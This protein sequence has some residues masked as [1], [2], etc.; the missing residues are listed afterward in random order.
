MP[1]HDGRVSVWLEPEKKRL[2]WYAP[3]GSRKSK[4]IIDYDSLSENEIENL[5][6]TLELTFNNGNVNPITGIL[7]PTVITMSQLWAHYQENQ[8]LHL[9]GDSRKC[10]EA[11]WRLYIGPR[12]GKTKIDLVKTLDVERWLSEVKK[13][14]GK[15]PSKEY[16]EKIRNVMSAMFSHAMRAELCNQNPISCGGSNIGHGGK[17]GTGAGA[18]ILGEFAEKRSL[19]HF[20]PEQNLAILGELEVRDRALVLLDAVLGLRRGELGGLHWEDCRFDADVFVIRHSFDWKG[21]IENPPKTERSAAKLP[22]HA[23]LK[24]ALLMWQKETPYQRPQDYVFPSQKM[25]GRKPVDLKEVFVKKIRPVIERLGFAQPRDRYGWHSF[26]HGLGTAL[27]DLTRDKLTVR[28]LL[29]HSSTS[30]TERYMHGIDPRL[31]EAQDKLVTA[32]GLKKPQ[33]RKKKAELLQ[34]PH[35]AAIAA[36]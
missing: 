30:I 14:N 24:D 10:Y 27:W 20:K 9:R 28:D 16:V 8:L 26:R 7:L 35:R 19:I 32:I 31:V 22:M 15:R 36:S 17:R 23:V 1:K 21:G 2:R 6:L 12:W 13:Q 3:D 18:R 34:M 25:R 5:R 11:M 4:A 33:R 29:R